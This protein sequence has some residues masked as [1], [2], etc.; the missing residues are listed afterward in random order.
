M[1]GQLPQGEEAGEEHGHREGENENVGCVVKIVFDHQRDG[2]LLVDILV[3]MLNQ[4]HHQKDDP[5]GYQAE[6]QR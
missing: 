5:E 1:F 4:I 3:H 6:D 2:S